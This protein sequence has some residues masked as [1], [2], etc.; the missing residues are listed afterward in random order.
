MD[1]KSGENQ[2]GIQATNI[3]LLPIATLVKIF[4]HLNNQDLI[5]VAETCKTCNQVIFSTDFLTSKYPSVRIDFQYLQYNRNNKKFTYK[6][7]NG[8]FKDFNSLLK[9][10]RLYQNYIL[11]NFNKEA[12]DRLGLTW[13]QLFKKQKNVRCIKIKAD[14]IDL[15]QLASLLRLTQRLVYIEIDGYRVARFEEPLTNEIISIK[16]LSHLKI[17]SFLDA[18]PHIFK[19]FQNCTMLKSISL[20]TLFFT[21]NKIKLINDF[22]FANSQL[23]QLELIGLDSH[24]ALLTF[25]ANQE[26]KFKLKKINIEYNGYSLN[27]HTF[28]EFFCHQKSL[29][30]VKLSLNLQLSANQT[31]DGRYCG[32][33][34]RHIMTLSHLTSLSLIVNK[35]YFQ[36]E[37]FNYHNKYIRKLSFENELG[38]CNELLIGLLKCLPNLESLELNC[39]YS[40][41]I[42][43][44]LP[45]LSNLRHLKI[46]N[47]LQGLL[48]KIKCGNSLESI[49]LEYCYSK[50]SGADWFEFLHN[51][52]NVKYIE[53]NHSIEFV[54]DSIL[55]IITC[56][57]PLLEHFQISNSS[58]KF[59]T[60]NA[61]KIF[62][63]N[64]ANLKFLKL[65]D[66]PNKT[67]QNKHQSFHD[68]LA[69]VKCVF[70][71]YIICIIGFLV[72][73]VLMWHEKI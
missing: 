50:N 12:T 63:K 58:A 27:M 51:N 30:E 15:H 68:M 61:Y 54:S 26:I 1:L 70:I 60:E 44:L 34:I 13:L 29:E 46:T 40:D 69:N 14:F 16:N 72:L 39:D 57:C 41:N 8:E 36:S 31:Q 17:S 33:I 18:S 10:S 52:P 55:E 35:F 19:I 3:D 21:H 25:E 20:R 4:L 56:A 43:A 42:L 38:G 6:N 7:S 32:T 65:T 2:E 22:I 24:S 23:E 62:Q 9:T 28:T 71:F 66:K 48:E 45:L 5:S 67:M 47:Y 49:C 73:I 37:N 64:C 11:D 53:I 59:L